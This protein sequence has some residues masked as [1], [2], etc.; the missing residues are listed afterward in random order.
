MQTLNPSQERSA[1]ALALASKP[2]NEARRLLNEAR[3]IAFAEAAQGRLG[4]GLTVLMDALD[5][6]PMS[7]DLLSDMSALLLSAGE[8]NHAVSYALQAL[9][10][11]PDHGPSQYTL[12][13][14]LSG[15]GELEQARDILSRL[16]QGPG[17]D[18]LNAEGP[19]L[20]PLARLEL[21]RLQEL[22]NKSNID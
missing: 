4:Q 22:H 10:V 3:N 15:L 21:A 11:Q 7:H 1:S 18:S 8:L 14:A 12:G 6:E 16:L 2:A 9:H 5:V 17:L 19:E 20:V 13:F